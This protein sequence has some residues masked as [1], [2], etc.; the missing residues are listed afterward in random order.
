MAIT[1]AATRARIKTRLETITGIKLAHVYAPRSV[2]ENDCPC[3]VVTAREAD[4]S[5]HTADGHE[6]RRRWEF[7]LLVGP[8]GEGIV[9]DLQKALDPFFERVENEC[10]ANL[11]LD[12]LD[13]EL[14]HILLDE[15]SGEGI[16]EYPPNS[17]SLFFGCVWSAIITTKRAVTTGL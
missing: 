4:H 17:G 2:A 7:A 6:A 5:F 8:V 10:A 14:I 9:G 13:S 16:I 11:Q 1:L 12:E 3:F 15:D